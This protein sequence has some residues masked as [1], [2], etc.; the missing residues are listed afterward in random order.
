[1]TK[2]RKYSLQDL[3]IT[4]AELEAARFRRLSQRFDAK[5][6]S[7]GVRVTPLSR[8]PIPEAVLCGECRAAAEQETV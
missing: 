1:M 6:E 4:E 5:C 8:F 2:P 7:C 3:T